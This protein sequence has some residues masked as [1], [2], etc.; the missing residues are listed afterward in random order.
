MELIITLLTGLLCLA[1]YILWNAIKTLKE[2]QSQP[3]TFGFDPQ[4]KDREI[5]DIAGRLNTLELLADKLEPLEEIAKRLE[6][7][8]TIE[9]V[10]DKLQGIN[11]IAEQ[12]AELN[13]LHKTISLETAINLIAKQFSELNRLHKERAH[14]SAET[15]NFLKNIHT[16]LRDIAHYTKYPK[17]RTF[18]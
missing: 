2:L 1:S 10:A 15:N 16:E 7:L 18:R 3:K 6:R 5:G 12:L 17:R 4:L 14:E 8:Q 11:A 9:I 13:L